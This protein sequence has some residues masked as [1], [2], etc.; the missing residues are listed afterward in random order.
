MVVAHVPPQTE[1]H[2]QENSA[3][4]VKN[5]TALMEMIAHHKD[6]GVLLK[7]RLFYLS[8]V[9]QLMDLIDHF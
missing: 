9:L 6:P 4:Y 7:I 1:G 5:H 3:V 8:P 2:S